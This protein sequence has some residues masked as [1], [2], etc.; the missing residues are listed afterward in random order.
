MYNNRPP[1]QSA[2]THTSIGLELFNDMR[3]GE[4]LDVGGEF[5]F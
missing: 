2:R 5:S 4:Q 1:P 3:G